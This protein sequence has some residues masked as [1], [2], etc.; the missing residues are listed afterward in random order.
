MGF[1]RKE[2]RRAL[3]LFS[4]RSGLVEESLA[5]WGYSV[6]RLDQKFRDVEICCDIMDWD[7]RAEFAP[8]HFHLIA[9]GPPCT[10]Y[11]VAKTVGVRN[12]DWADQLVRR[13]KEIIDYFNPPVWLIEN[14]RTGLLKS[15]GLLYSCFFIDVDYCQFSDWGYKKPTRLWVSPSLS[16]VANVVCDPH[17]C[18]QMVDGKNGRR[19]HREHLGGNQMEFSTR[20]KKGCPV[21]W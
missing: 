1:P 3:H 2:T 18:S 6:T 13:T 9:S 8:G 5:L 14:P 16:K 21:I 15:R 10:E 7:F 19:V 17:T 12:L 20:L 4:G 11:S